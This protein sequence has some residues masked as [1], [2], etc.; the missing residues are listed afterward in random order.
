MIA[1]TATYIFSDSHSF[2]LFLS[3][4]Q[5]FLFITFYAKLWS[6]EH[7]KSRLHI[8]ILLVV[9]LLYFCV[10]HSTWPVR[11]ARR[12]SIFYCY[13]GLSY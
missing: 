13:L 12:V 6:I 4:I 1:K 11:N 10:I 3:G 5:A 8:V 9:L 7:E 2:L